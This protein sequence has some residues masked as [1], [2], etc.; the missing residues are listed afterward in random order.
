M[1][2][3]IA[4]GGGPVERPGPSTETYD[5][6]CDD[7]CRAARERRKIT[8]L[9][10]G[11]LRTGTLVYWPGQT[12]FSHKESKPKLRDRHDRYVRFCTDAVVEIGEPS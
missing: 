11:Q 5:P 9:V 12:R 4:S 10:N 6:G 8:V 3:Q 2:A 7:G 1:T